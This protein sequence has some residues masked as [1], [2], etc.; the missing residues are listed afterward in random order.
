MAK[1][2]FVVL[3]VAIFSAMV[4]VG[5]VIPFLPL[6]AQTLGASGIWLG[7]IFSGFSLSRSI[8]M[9][10]IG[11]LSDKKG[12]KIFLCIGLLGYSVVSL[13]YIHADKA[14]QLFIVRFM[15]G[16]F[17]AMILPIAMAYIGEISP[18]KKEGTFMGSFNVA[19]FAG[20]GIGPF[21]G[22]TINDHFGMD[23]AFY[24]MGGLS[25]TAFL[26]I[27]L[28][29]PELHLY[30]KGW[31][32]PRASYK[33]MLGRN[34][35]RGITVFRL[36]N[37][38]GRGMV[39]TFLPIFASQ[40]LQ[41]NGGQIGLLIS[42]NILLTSV[43]QAPFGKLADKMSRLKLIVFGGCMASFTI[44]LIPF[45][46]DFNQLLALNIAMGFAGAISLPATSALA[47]EEGR[48]MGMGSVMGIFDMAMSI[49]LTSGPLMGG[50]L[51]DSLG[52]DSIFIFGGCIGFMAV[53]LFVWFLAPAS[54][55]R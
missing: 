54:C 8:F 11:R 49:G 51:M 47:V 25:L 15:Q 22:G 40:R 3:F 7:I 28:F 17:A 38:M 20:F 4:G 21:M 12:R 35:I 26:M 27:L 30:K 1:R 44:L 31:G 32:H 5:I 41:L 34:V 43:L 36:V 33:V 13:G 50:L 39:A 18:V 10:V 9:P 55:N 23:M 52:L 42:A 2:V 19:L 37:A 53:G 24:A 29:L 16:F 46:L 48:D 45:T 14:S 6:Y